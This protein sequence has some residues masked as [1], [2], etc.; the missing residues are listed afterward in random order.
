MRRVNLLPK[1]HRIPESE[2][3][4]FLDIC[5]ETLHEN[6]ERP[7]FSKQAKLYDETIVNVCTAHNP[8]QGK[9][10]CVLT[11]DLVD[12]K[13]F[14]EKGHLNGEYHKCFYSKPE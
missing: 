6:P 2:S 12:V 11:G 13:N 3:A 4:S 8:K 14:F 1:N 7:C 9:S 5:I 10:D